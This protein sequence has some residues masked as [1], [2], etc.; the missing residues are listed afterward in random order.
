MRRILLAIFFVLV[1][2]LCAAQRPPSSLPVL[3]MRDYDNPVT[4]PRF[5][6]QLK[7]AAQEVG[8]FALL[9]FGIEKQLLNH[10]YQSMNGFFAMAVD[11]KMRYCERALNGQRGYCPGE[12]AK[13]QSCSDFKEFFSVG[14]ELIGGGSTSHDNVWPKEV[15]MRL[16]LVTLFNEI[17]NKRSFL[18]EAFSEALGQPRDFFKAMT[19]EGESL[20][21]VFHYPAR[22][23]VQRFWAAPHTDINLFT[24]FF[25][26]T[27]PGLQLKTKE[28][29]WL[30]IVV[31]EGAVIVGCGD[32]M[33]NLTNGLFRSAVHRVVD[34]G[35][36][37]NRYAIAFYTHGRYTDRM[38]PLPRCISMTGGVQRYVN[39]TE[40]ELLEERLVDL[41][42][43]TIE[44][45]D[46]LAK[47]GLMERQLLL[48]H[49][50]VQAMQELKKA[51]LAS[52]AVL[53][54]LSDEK[55]D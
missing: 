17:E 46:H 7:N 14:R 4:R 48:G 29:E 40:R 47:S 33:Q 41:G 2:P 36:G 6:R 42:L 34:E 21:R 27:E 45:M 10:A 15:N 3:D 1:I 35:K 49:A 20:L 28:G 55:L 54:A 44:V 51:G 5:V 50:S 32:M 25:P 18:E 52:D 23:P 22:P 11:N 19:R 37:K 16:P 53:K 30:Q 13:G 38:D 31:P 24:I 9:N 39:A 12:C 26:A 43:A 8:F